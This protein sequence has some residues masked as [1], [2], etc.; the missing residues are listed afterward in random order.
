MKRMVLMLAMILAVGT[1]GAA[2][3]T[4]S[5]D[6]EDFSVGYLDGQD[7]WTNPAFPNGEALVITSG[8]DGQAVQLYS[9][10]AG[11]G[12]DATRSLAAETI[13]N[14]F[15]ISLDMKAESMT[16]FPA[17]ANAYVLLNSKSSN[18][19][20]LFLNFDF[21]YGIYILNPTRDGW[22][23]SYV[24][25]GTNPFKLTLE[26]D[27]NYGANGGYRFTS[28]DLVTHVVSTPYYYGNDCY[29]LSANYTGGAADANGSISIS[30][31]GCIFDNV[32]IVPEP[33]T[34]SLLALGSLLMAR[35][36]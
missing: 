33:L 11:V 35:R 30:S 9:A 31:T 6:F 14:S 4:Y 26:F 2:W 16:G 1:S 19:N 29:G 27:W 34:V 25:P 5:T 12:G 15:T 13:N 24:N 22:L 3:A 10:S 36:K 23:Y 18:Q 20:Y 32:A 17:G 8:F 28:E 7:G 21:A